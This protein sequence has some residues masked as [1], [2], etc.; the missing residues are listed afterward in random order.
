[1]NARFRTA[2]ALLTVAATLA[3]APAAYAID[4]DPARTQ[5]LV[6]ERP[7]GLIGPVTAS[8]SSEVTALVEAI[9]RQRMANYRAIAQKNGTPIDAVQ[10]IAGQKQVEKALQSGWYAMNPDGSWTK[11]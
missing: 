7:D 2:F 9:N 6:G 3:L 4:L 1:M 11:K 8:P 10:A 5:G